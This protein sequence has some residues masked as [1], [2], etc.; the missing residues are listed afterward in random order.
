M[1]AGA[2]GT[3]GLAA[4]GTARPGSVWL[5]LHRARLSLL[6]AP[7][8]AGSRGR[9][10]AL[11]RWLGSRARTAAARSSAPLPPAALLKAR[12]CPLCAVR[13]ESLHPRATER[14]ELRETHGDHRAQLGVCA[15]R[16]KKGKISRR[17][18]HPD[19]AKSDET[20]LLY[21]PSF[22]ECR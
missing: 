4:Q 11:R 2:G 16:N 6:P 12:L 15:Q 5:L 22:G 1:A 19:L 20:A 17:N 3:A 10:E 18:H 13:K 9:Q 21:V 14:A 8:S 7:R